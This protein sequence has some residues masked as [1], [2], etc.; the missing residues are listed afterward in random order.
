MLREILLELSLIGHVI[1]LGKGSS[2]EL[3][4]WLRFFII[5]K[6][7]GV[8]LF[9]VDVTCLGGGIPTTWLYFEAGLVDKDI[10][11]DEK[12][13]S[14]NLEGIGIVMIISLG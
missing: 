11:N 14:S 5:V 2:V 10:I 8:L 3:F 6:I 9:L 12:G 4:G 7:L 1:W 13:L